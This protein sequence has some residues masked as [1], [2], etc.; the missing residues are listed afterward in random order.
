MKKYTTEERISAFWSKVNKNG[1]I[2][3]HC[4]ELGNCWEWTAS[5]ARNGY[6][7]VKFNSKTNKM[8]HRISWIIAY[9][10]IP[11]NLFVL[12]SCDNRKCVN[13]KH[14]FLGTAKDNTRDM[15]LKNRRGNYCKVTNE[16]VCKIRELYSKGNLT[17]KEIGYIFGISQTH[18][19]SIVRRVK[20]I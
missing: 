6:G 2:P 18:V 13:P 1:S 4:P 19:G 11:D 12:H 3:Q 5:L 20:R 17:Q 10:D 15:D 16:Q 8:P 7:I 9:G 14:L